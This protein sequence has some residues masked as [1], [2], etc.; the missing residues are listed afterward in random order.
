MSERCSGVKCGEAREGASLMGVE[1]AA[2]PREEGEGGSD[3][4]FR[5]F[6]EGFQEDNDPK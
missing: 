5:N 6:G 4:S 2:G 1:K 3:D